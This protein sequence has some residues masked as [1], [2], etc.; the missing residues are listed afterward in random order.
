MRITNEILQT[1]I[2]ALNKAVKAPATQY[3]EKSG[4]P[5]VGNFHLVTRGSEY[6]I[7]RVTEG[8]G[9]SRSDIQGFYTKKDLHGRIQ[10][11]MSGLA[12]KG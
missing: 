6:G 2:D 10:A 11:F 12:F 8:G 9:Q 3:D 1:Q 4:K 7:A 5:N